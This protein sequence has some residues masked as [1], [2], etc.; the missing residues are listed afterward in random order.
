[1]TNYNPL[2]PAPSPDPWVIRHDGFYYYCRSEDDAITIIR[3]RTLT[4]LGQGEKRTVW[5][6]PA[7]GPY[8]RELW[9]P[10]LHRLRGK[11]Y[12]YVAADDGSND[13]HRMWVL[14][15]ESDDPLS[16]CGERVLLSAPELA[17]ER[18]IYPGG[19]FVNEGP[20]VL[21][22]GDKIHVVYSASHSVT[23]HY[24]LGLLTC[25]SGDVLN[26]AAWVKT[27]YPVFAKDDAAGVYAVGHCSF[28]KSPDG[29]E[30]WLIFHAM[31]AQDGG[32]DS[33]SARAQKFLWTTDGQPLFGTPA[34]TDTPL[35]RPSG[36][37]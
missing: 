25:A 2:L 36:E 6:P 10:E 20:Q 21:V 4:G 34:G 3:S 19:P 16:V 12:I 31:P 27:P 17:W 22:H 1:M 13:N 18:Q 33:R 14:E 28:T 8:S 24:C 29:S 5:K 15:G 32:W 9:A 23:E 11:W 30:D 7:T 26:P 37:D 35:R